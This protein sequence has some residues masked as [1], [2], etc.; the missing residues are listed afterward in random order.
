MRHDAYSAQVQTVGVP[1]SLHRSV[2]VRSL[3][4]MP[5]ASDAE[6]LEL[7]AIDTEKLVAE[8]SAKFG[9]PRPVFGIGHFVLSLRIV[10]NR[11][12][13]ND[14]RVTTRFRAEP[15][16][17]VP[18]PCPVGKAV[19][20]PQRQ[21][22]LVQNDAQYRPQVHARVLCILV[23]KLLSTVGQSFIPSRWCW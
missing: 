1:T 9:G 14:H 11:K 6:Q 8:D 22:V 19:I 20:A 2:R 3:M 16:S 5:M 17:V 21:W 12:Q 7:G 18:D 15:L 10:Q 13:R 23:H 4:R